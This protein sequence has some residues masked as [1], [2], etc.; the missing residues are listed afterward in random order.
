LDVG[1][2][3]GEETAEGSGEGHGRTAIGLDGRL[4]AGSSSSVGCLGGGGVDGEVA[5]DGPLLADDG[6]GS[7]IELGGHVEEVDL[8]LARGR[9]GGSEDDERVDLEVGV[10]EIDVDRVQSDDEID[11]VLLLLRR[12]DFGEQRGCD[13]L[14]GRKGFRGIGGGDGDVEL[15]GVGID[16]ADIDAALGG[17]EDGVELAGRS[18]ADVVLGVGRMGQER[19]DEEGCQRAGD[20]LDLAGLAS[21]G[22]DPL[23]GIGPILVEGEQASLAASL[24]Q[25]IGL[26]DEL[27][28]AIAGPGRDEGVVGLDRLRL[29]VPEQLDQLGR[30]LGGGGM[31]QLQL[32][33]DGLDSRQPIREEQLCIVLGDRLGRHS[34]DGRGSRE[35]SWAMIKVLSVYF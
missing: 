33:M 14:P 15:E 5:G 17:E 16:I 4:A 20:V 9:L 7:L 26:G 31:G 12:V 27:G 3:W 1:F 21:S 11:D 35:K 8:D 29:V 13:V 24:D 23:L 34:R 6:F 30:G 19:L 18:D 10:V 25:L 22:D 2:G 28:G 32:R